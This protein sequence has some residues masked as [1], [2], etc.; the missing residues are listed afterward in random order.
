MRIVLV[1]FVPVRNRCPEFVF[2]E[3]REFHHSPVNGPIGI[4]SIPE[5]VRHEDSP[6]CKRFHVS[7]RAS[8]QCEEVLVV[9]ANQPALH[10][11]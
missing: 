5:G 6:V 7:K 3:R 1:R 2:D 10:P 11:M 4:K 9:S 8:A